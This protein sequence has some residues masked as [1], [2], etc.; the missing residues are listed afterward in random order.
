MTARD[1]D[2]C[3]EVL[4]S[5]ASGYAASQ[6]RD[7]T[8]VIRVACIRLYMSRAPAQIDCL[9]SCVFVVLRCLLRVDGCFCFVVTSSFNS[10]WLPVWLRSVCWQT[11]CE[12]RSDKQA[13][14]ISLGGTNYNVLSKYCLQL[15]DPVGDPGGTL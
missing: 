5:H 6:A 14:R 10:C 2:V 8:D 12:I 9:T 7:S 4:R 11:G 15:Y 13:H 3:N 1:Y